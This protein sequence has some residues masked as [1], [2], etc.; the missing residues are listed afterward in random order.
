[1]KN[2]TAYIVTL[3]FLCN[4]IVP[5]Y[6]ASNGGGGEKATGYLALDPP[7][8]VNIPD[9][10]S[11]RFLQV[12]VQLKINPPEAATSVIEHS[13]AIRHNMILL[14]SEQRAQD[15]YSTVGKERLRGKALKE[16]RT[17]LQGKIGEAEIENI[18]FTT[19]IIQ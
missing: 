5:A 1:M 17:I 10:N 2:L 14:L 8:T 6:A 3:I 4:V 7:F 15:L 19:F 16:I 18:F 9:E 12:A 11:L 13:S